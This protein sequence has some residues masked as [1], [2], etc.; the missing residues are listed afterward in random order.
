[1][2]QGIGRAKTPAA[3]AI[4]ANKIR[5]AKGTERRGAV[6][7]TSGPQITSGKTAKDSRS[8]GIDPF[9]L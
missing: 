9:S 7:L 4:D 8:A 3:R 6:S 5:V 1:L 2:E